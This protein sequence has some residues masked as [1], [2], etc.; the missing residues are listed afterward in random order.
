MAAPPPAFGALVSER[1]QRTAMR[2]L[3]KMLA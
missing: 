1:R 3:M 2:V